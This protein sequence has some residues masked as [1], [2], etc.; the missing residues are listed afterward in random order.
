MEDLQ[1]G[2]D[3]FKE[4]IY[5]DTIGKPLNEKKKQFNDVYE[6]LFYTMPDLIDK[7]KVHIKDPEFLK[8]FK[9][10]LEL[11][12]KILQNIFVIN[13]DLIKWKKH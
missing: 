11:L 10:I 7:I 12:Q 5:N 1:E 13:M 2:V 9:P 6:S 8:E 3:F 4:N